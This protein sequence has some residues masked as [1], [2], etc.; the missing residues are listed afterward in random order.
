MKQDKE[1]LAAVMLAKRAEEE[2][3]AKKLGGK[4]QLMLNKLEN[5]ETPGEYTLSGVELGGPRIRIL[6][7]QIAY[8]KSL[9]NLHLT[10]SGVGDDDG[11]EIAK[12]LYNNTTLRKLELE[13]NNLGIKTAKEFAK[14]LKYNKTL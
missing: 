10:R 14:A 5:D 13:G 3:Q 12:I 1:K 9:K 11:M 6:V 4:L 2:E 7:S 8:N